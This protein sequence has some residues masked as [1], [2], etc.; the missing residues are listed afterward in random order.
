MKF[1]KS[2]IILTAA[3]IAACAIS[4]AFVLPA[5]ASTNDNKVS[6]AA[7]GTE[8]TGTVNQCYYTGGDGDGPD[9]F[10]GTGSCSQ[11][12]GEWIEENGTTR[13]VEGKSTDNSKGMLHLISP[14]DKTI[15]FYG[16]DLDLRGAVISG[17]GFDNEPL[18]EHMDMVDASA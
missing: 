11:R 8:I 5:A 1:Q 3:M 15:Y 10:D 6:S 9:W 4:G 16:E 13:F 12:V 7:A 2:E 17:C 14:P 18:S